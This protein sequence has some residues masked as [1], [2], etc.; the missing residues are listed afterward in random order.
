MNELT[1]WENKERR[2][3]FISKRAA[4]T[5]LEYDNVSANVIVSA[6]MGSVIKS[7]RRCNEP[8]GVFV[9]LLGLEGALRHGY[10]HWIYVRWHDCTVDPQ[11]ESEWWEDMGMYFSAWQYKSGN[12][13]TA[14]SML[15]QRLVEAG[16]L[17]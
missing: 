2:D 12:Y 16:Y 6:A 17:R 5:K 3:L 8:V 11:T 13:E 4:L 14:K 1:G 15:I 7:A 10:I 9:L